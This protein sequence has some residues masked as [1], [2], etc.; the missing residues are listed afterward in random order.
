[1]ADKYLVQDVWTTANHCTPWESEE[2]VGQIE[3]NSKES[4]VGVDSTEKMLEQLEQEGAGSEDHEGKD[5]QWSAHANRP[6]SRQKARADTRSN[7]KIESTRS[8]SQ[9]SATSEP[10]EMSETNASDTSDRVRRAV[11]MR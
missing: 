8:L 4:L 2:A 6:K 5:K 11:S 1:M 7:T 3:I 10:S 9:D